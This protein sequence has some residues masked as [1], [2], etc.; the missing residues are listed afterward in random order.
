M[1]LKNKSK[2]FLFVIF[3]FIFIARTIFV[4]LF[5]KSRD[6]LLDP[7]VRLKQSICNLQFKLSFTFVCNPDYKYRVHCNVLSS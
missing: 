6:W 5:K 1:S 3:I 7:F 2:V 4:S